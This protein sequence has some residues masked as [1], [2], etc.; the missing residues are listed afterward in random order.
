[1]ALVDGELCANAVGENAVI[2]VHPD[3]GYSRK[4]WPATIETDAGPAFGPNY[5]QLN[6]IA[7][8][9]TL[10]TSY[11]SA[12]TDRMSK[13]RPGHQNFRVD[14]RGVI[15]SGDTREVVVRGLTRPHSARLHAGRVW[16]DNSGYGEFGVTCGERFEPVARLSGWTRGLTFVEDIAFVGTSRVL[17]RFQHYAP[18]VDVSSA[19]CALHAVD[20]QSGRTLASVRWPAG[21][22][23]FG[24]DWLPS[25]AVSGL[26]FASGGSEQRA[27][28]RFYRYES[29]L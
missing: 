11:Y 20:A 8:G 23:I 29:E 12:S 3:G 28:Q 16:V 19:E 7:A 5:L 13:R 18:G 25:R 9:E 1:M 27:V 15:F 4:W 2:V 26:P 17:P 24:V 21:N 22:Q 6:S 14:K 10:E